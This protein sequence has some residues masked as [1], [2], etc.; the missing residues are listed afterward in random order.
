VK[1]APAKTAGYSGTPLSKKLG[2]KPD[3]TLVLLAA[4]EGFERTLAPLPE[5]VDVRRDSRARGERVVAFVG[6]LAELEKR[7]TAAEKSVADGGT[8]WIAWPKKTSP[9]ASDVDE[10][11][12]RAAGLARGWV[13]YKVCAVDFTWSGLAFARRK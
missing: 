13:D 3:T 5:R 6:K 7:F 9:A 8:M 11:L 12:V 1:R 2:V 4:P 10:N